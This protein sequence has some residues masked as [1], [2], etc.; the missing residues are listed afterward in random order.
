VILTIRTQILFCFLLLASQARGTITAITVPSYFNQTNVSNVVTIYAGRAD[1]GLVCTT[2]DG[3]T[4]PCDSCIYLTNLGTNPTGGA[5]AFVPACNKTNVYPTLKFD[6]TFTSDTAGYGA[7]SKVY[8]VNGSANTVGTLVSPTIITS[9]QP[10]TAR[11]TWANICGTFS[12][13]TKSDCTESFT[14][15]V[16]LG[17]SKDGT[18]TLTDY[19]TLQINYRW[20]DPTLL[21]YHTN[22][23]LTV[24]TDAVANEGVCGFDIRP[25]D[26]KVIVGNVLIPL[27]SAGSSQTSW[28]TPPGDSS[29]VNYAGLKVYYREVPGNDGTTPPAN[30]EWATIA[31]G[32]AGTFEVDNL[33]IDSDGAMSQTRIKSLSNDVTYVFAIATYD[34]AG[35]ITNFSDIVPGTGNF[36]DTT[37]TGTHYGRPGEV[38]G[39][40]SDKKCFIATAAFGSEMA[41]QVDLLRKFR[42]EFMVKNSI[43]KW[44]V[45]RYYKLS[46]PAAEF[47]AHHETLRK[48]VR[49]LLSPIIG[50]AQ[51]CLDYGIFV[52]FLLLL[53]LGLLAREIAK[54]TSLLVLSFKV[55]QRPR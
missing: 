11:F 30:G 24:P 12:P 19:F 54:R 29:G 15:S 38:V 33:P 14:K 22:C 42:N 50:W 48:L 16:Q 32:A 10:V 55:S 25:G 6:V 7:A 31:P 41:P 49:V 18:A 35:N 39:L 27:A 2:G 53:V 52:G 46:P 37:K 5:T 51:F 26:E 40:L 1:P 34:Q 4:S 43:G 47:I 23:S 17:I 28:P 20:V 3:G 45:K 21:Q 44:L 13:N 8:M 36:F 9:G